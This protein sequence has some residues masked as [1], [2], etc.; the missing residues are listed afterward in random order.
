MLPKYIEVN[1]KK[2]T[3]DTSY[4]TAI[5]CFEIIDDKNISDFE[6]SLAITFL[7]IGDIPTEYYEEVQNL[8]ILYLQCGKSEKEIERLKRIHKTQKDM[9]YT[10]DESYITASFMS[11]YQIDLTEKDIHWWKFISLLEGLSPECILN[12]IRD[13]R[14]CDLSQY[15]SKTKSQILK[16]REQ[17][18]LPI[19]QTAEE[20]FMLDEF[21]ARLAGKY[22]EWLE[23]QKGG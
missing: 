23:K 9:D 16:L 7:L 13:I 4:K 20:Q 14:T 22:T 15:D 6:R 2:Y 18:A 21:E 11:D 3:L 10:L 17:I 5:K 12:R 8:L 19:E 1:N